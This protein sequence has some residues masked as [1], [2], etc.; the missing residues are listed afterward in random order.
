MTTIRVL[1]PV[2]AITA[3]GTTVDLPSAS[4]RRLLAALA[5]HHPNAVRSSW[6]CDVLEVTPGA[7]RQTVARLRRALGDALRTTTGGYRLDADVDA[8]EA[9]RRFEGADGDP[10]QLAAVIGLW[11][12]PT[13]EEF[14]DEAWAIGDVRRL[15]EVRAAAIEELAELRLNVGDHD[16]ALRDLD[17]HI[18]AHPYRDRP[19]GVLMRAL[20]AS[21]RQTEAL[22]VY[23]EYRTMLGDEVGTEPSDAL[24]DI[25]RRIATGWDGIDPGASGEEVGALQPHDALLDQALDSNVAGVGRADALTQLLGAADGSLRN[26]VS[27]VAIAG[28]A[29]IGK[30]T[31]VAD[32]GRALAGTWDVVYGRCDEHVGAPFS[33]LDEMVG[34]L[35]DHL[36]DEQLTRHAARHGGDL[37]RLVPALAD[38]LEASE[39]PPSDERTA[40]QLLFDAVTDVVARSASARP[41]V[42]ALDDIQWSGPA[43]TLLLGHLARHLGSAPVL[44]V[45]TIRTTADPL[46]DHVRDL[47]ADLAR[48]RLDHMDL[49]GLERDE[50]AALVRARVDGTQRRDVAQ[51][52]DLLHDE[53]AGN[54]LFA[55]QLLAHWMQSGRLTLNDT[56]VRVARARDVDVPP[57]VRDLVWQRVRSL[58]DRA[59]DILSAAAVIGAVFDEATLTAMTEYDDESVVTL[60]DR[61]IAAGVLV[62]DAGAVRFAHALVAHALETDLRSR[63]RRM[64]HSRAY[65]ALLSTHRATRELAPR[66]AHHA[67]LADRSADLLDRAIEAGDLALADLA[68]DEATRWYTI[69]LDVAAQLDRPTAVRADLLVR[70]GEARAFAGHPNAIEALTQGASLAA[71][72]GAESVLVRAALLADRG[73]MVL[74][75][76]SEDQLALMERALRASDDADLATRARLTASVA[77]RLIRTDRARDRRALAEEALELARATEDPEVFGAVA[78]RVLHALWAP[79]AA[80]RRHQ[81]AHEATT[82]V[83]HIDDPDLVFLAFFAAYGAAVCATD[84]EAARDWAARVREVADDVR[85]PHLRWALGVLDG[86]EAIMEARFDE[87]ER[88]VAETADRGV[89]LGAEATIVVFTGQSFVLGT[90]MGRHAELLPIVEQGLDTP[91]VELTFRLAHAIV[92]C[93]TGQTDHAAALLG[94]VM[95]GEVE[96]TPIDVIRLTEVLGLVVV[97]LELGDADAAAWLLPQVEPF[98]DEVSFN[99]IT[100]HGPVAAYVGK[101]LSVLGRPGEGAPPQ[102]VARA[103]PQ[104]FGG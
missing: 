88:I 96:R 90:Y 104:R 69:A 32:F 6:L 5:V 74:G 59:D 48:E 22:R 92:S 83:A 35:A 61:A 86:F 9:L 15:D 55:D 103:G 72:A 1:G 30:T 89:Q 45:L 10:E 28:E 44:F 7:L 27:A 76:P 4:Q 31:L 68:P 43:V 29:G 33:P 78:V 73:T 19:R 36:A 62:E 98:V 100:S 41:V 49:T 79:G 34:R 8:T 66:L 94:S 16:R 80:Q 85:D 14:R 42:F 84:D 77:Q 25:E 50:L 20:A 65:D 11:A 37:L 38:R 39:A 52:A 13:L 23:R 97:A 60:L 58:G 93:E 75:Q 99:S 57:T 26:G 53:T 18:A 81:L 64:L 17:V 82:A 56:D 24:V 12:G 101:L 54:A 67:Q 47:L 46:P 51:V 91:D 63:H 70:L 21:G 95:R 102:L 87:A 3:D 71:D 2:H 40:R